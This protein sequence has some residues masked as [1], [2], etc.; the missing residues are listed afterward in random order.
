MAIGSQFLS[1]VTDLRDEL[2]RSNS[3]SV[4]VDDLPSLKRTLNK[5]YAT[6]AI[7][8]TWPHLRRVFDRKTL[9]AGQRYYDFPTDL[10]HDR[11]ENAAIWYND[12]PHKTVRG[13]GFEEYAAYDSEA[14]ERSDPVQR[15]DVRDVAG[16]IQ[17]EVWPLP[18]S[19]Q[20]IQFIGERATPKLVGDTDVC[21]L[22]DNMIVMLAAA[23]LF[24]SK[25]ER[26][27]ALAD[28]ERHRKM[29][30]ARSEG[31]QRTFRLGL[32]EIDSNRMPNTATIRVN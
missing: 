6:A 13:I 29:L 28:A 16:A 31:G 12:L 18:A 22:D 15:W 27:E 7:E 24:K 9:N 8:F 14:D 30:K 23:K 4:G 11:I 3:V 17:F 32:G 20:S 26:N 1:L 19:A 25:D 5:A 2:R 21:F 10:N